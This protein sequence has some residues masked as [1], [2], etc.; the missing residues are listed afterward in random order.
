MKR[1]RVSI[2]SL[3]LKG[4]R[5]EDRHAVA[6]GL[7][8]ELSRQFADPQFAHRVMTMSDVWRLRAGTAAVKPG[9]SPQRIGTAAARQI[10]KGMLS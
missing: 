3:V 7:S 1:I 9:A 8:Q 10:S 4:F 2:D 5:P 6:S